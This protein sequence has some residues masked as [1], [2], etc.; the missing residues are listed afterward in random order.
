MKKML[1]FLLFLPAV[2]F[3]VNAGDIS[4]T[5]R[6]STNTAWV[7][8]IFPTSN[9]ALLGT[10]SSGVPQAVTAGS[11]ITIASGT[12]SA[13]GSG[14]GTVTS[15]AASVP[16]F[17]SISG[18]PVTTSGTLAI[19]YSGSA[20]PVTSGG[21]GNITNTAHGV[22]IG[23]G[24]GAVAVTSAGSAGQVLTSN[25]A[26]A[27]PTY[28]T[29]TGTGTVTSVGV[30]V[31][32]FLSVSGT[33][34]TGA[35]TIALSLN[36]G[37]AIPVN[38]GGSGVATTT[39]YS[40][41]FTGTTSTGA[42][43]ADTG[44]GSSGQVLTS[45][46]AAAYPTWQ[47]V[48]GTGTVTTT[49]SPSSGQAAEFSGTTSITGVATTGSGSY[50]KATSPT[51]VTPI[52]GTPTSGTLT[53]AT[54]LPISTGVSGLG[55]G[56][57]TFL[58]T[59]S[60][61]NLATALTTALP[62]SK[63]GTGATTLTVHGVVVGNGTSAVAITSAGTAGQVLTSNGAS[64][65]PTFQSVSG[66]G[67]V[68]GPGSST[69]GH[70][71][72]FSGTTGKLLQDA[73]ITS[74]QT[75]STSAGAGDA[76]K[77]PLL[78]GSG[79]L[80]TSF[81]AT[82]T[83]AKGGTGLTTLT[84]NNVIL[85]AG[86]STP[87]FVAP[88]T[89]GNI[90]T[91]NG[92]TWTSAAP[93]TGTLPTQTGHSGEYLTTNGTTASWAAVSG[94]SGD[95][96]STLTAAEISVT[97]AVTATI[98]RMHVC[99]GTSANYTVTL[100]AVSGNTGKFIGFRMATG[101]T[102]LVTLD[103]ASS[104]TIDGATTRVMWTNEVAILFCDGTT[105]T[106]VAGK[107]IPMQCTATYGTGVSGQYTFS[108]APNEFIIGPNTS[109]LDTTGQMFNSG[110]SSIDIVRTGLYTCNAFCSE[111]GTLAAG[112]D[113]MVIGTNVNTN[114]NVPGGAD[115][116]GVEGGIIQGG[117]VADLSLTAAD[118]IKIYVYAT[119]N[120]TSRSFAGTQPRLIV[121]EIPTW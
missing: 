120:G 86:T 115:N 25:G 70:I 9:N 83:V 32:S 48:S 31:P 68:V 61:A 1:A 109:V 119:Q 81:F 77:I 40:P 2:L 87:T 65:D 49:G 50:V 67:D 88:S 110:N 28:Q 19:S 46:G 52:L 85:G 37:T 3:A 44:P 4:I 98:S 63:G 95:M 76:N 75:V 108:G 107:T 71:A 13:T 51:L 12:I 62:V 55:T 56:V 73:G 116:W 26:S 82:W 39:A 20:L 78:N 18:S 69:D 102:K 121:R 35:G 90:L 91:S 42:F 59:P 30:S 33:P 118:Q 21:T 72:V 114:G 111:T 24:S 58:A 7:N 23:N 38:S 41:I 43:K 89:S 74:A 22:L 45:N 66:T 15:V 16:A 80:D 79:V 8:Q 117:K 6:N 27:D 99:S 97:G 94:G 57:A 112:T 84:A 113:A 17:L 10:N 93:P 11:G 101:L 14:S 34:V 64:A 5:Q 105:W 47:S 103:G 100:P 53:N 96:L 60:G 104:E 106:K 54:G 92:T 29:V 36:S